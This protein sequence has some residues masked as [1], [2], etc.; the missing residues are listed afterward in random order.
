[1]LKEAYPMAK[2]FSEHERDL[3]RQN[4]I[5]ACKTCWNRYGYQKT[6][7]RE[8]AEMAN[9]SS[10]AFYQFYDSKEMLFVATA[11]DYQKDLIRLFH[12]NMQQY[13]GK[14]GVAESLKSLRSAMAGMP[15]LTSM[16]EEWP[17]IARKLPPGYIEQDFRKDMVRIAELI[18]QY[19]L[20]PKHSVE[21]VT[22]IIDMLMTGLTQFGMTPGETKEA[23]NLMIDAV[24]DGLFE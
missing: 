11:D 3:I 5:K 1:M 17:V 23:A 13:P 24:I 10:G 15:W 19:H 22:Q 2:S 14:Q 7:I 18:E 16:W 12:E 9:I 21:T 8:L 6:G 20:V 4:L